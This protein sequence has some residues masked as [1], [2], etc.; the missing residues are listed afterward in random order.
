MERK[1]GTQT[2][3]LR[4]RVFTEIA[5]AAFL[6]E[7]EE[8]KRVLQAVPGKIAVGEGEQMRRGRAAAA[9]Y[10][11][12]AA[13]EGPDEPLF[14]VIPAACE[15]CGVPDGAGGYRERPCAEICAAGAV[16]YDCAGRARIDPDQCVFCGRCMAVCPYDAVADRP[17]FLPLIRSLRRGETVIAEIAPAYPGQFGAGAGFPELKAALR[18]LGFSGAYEV[19]MSAGA[20]ASAEA[21]AYGEKVASGAQPYLI[22]VCCPAWAA[23]IRRFFPESAG[24]ISGTP[25]PMAATAAEIRRRHPGSKVAFI[26]ACPGKKEEAREASGKDVDFVLTFAELAA[27]FEARGIDPGAA[28]AEAAEECPVEAAAACAKG[29][30][31]AVEKCLLCRYPDAAERVVHAEG[32]KNCR[33]ALALAGEGTMDGRLIEG[34]ACPGGCRSGAGM[35]R[36]CGKPEKK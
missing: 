14:R 16:G 35:I 2:H 34:M 24:F 15:S 27:L 12:L 26:G 33:R 5:R 29:V 8:L 32:L 10:V 17:Q 28:S 3:S 23:L 1:Q 19:A 11:R 9:E 25:T 21:D 18:G 30:S 22:S 6:Y 20:V 4:G 36:A 7:G 31:G 13:G